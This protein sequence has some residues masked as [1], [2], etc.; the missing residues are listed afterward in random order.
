LGWNWKK[1]K[2]VLYQ[3]SHERKDVKAY[4]Q[5][6]FLPQMKSLQPHMMEWDEAPQVMDKSYKAN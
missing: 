2:N 1:V 6:V 5:D 4:Q 3:D